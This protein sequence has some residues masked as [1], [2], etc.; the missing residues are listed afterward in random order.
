MPQQLRLP[1]VATPSLGSVNV[2]E[3][4]DPPFRRASSDSSRAS[5]RRRSSSPIALGE[6]QLAELSSLWEQLE[7]EHTYQEEFKVVV[8]TSPCK[9]ICSR[10]TR[11]S[12]THSH[13]HAHMQCML[14]DCP[15]SSTTYPSS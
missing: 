7:L 13:M 15:T 3:T 10:V 6:R 5:Q 8:A 12:R 1:E 2:D 4:F 9:R 14:V 11:G